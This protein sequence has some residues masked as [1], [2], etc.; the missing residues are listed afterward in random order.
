MKKFLAIL[1]TI[2]AT[3]TTIVLVGLFVIPYVGN[4]AIKLIA[5]QTID[6]SIVDS[7]D[8]YQ[9]AEDL[10]IEQEKIDKALSNEEM[11]EYVNVIWQEILTK[12]AS[13]N[14]SIDEDLIKEKTKEFLEKAN[15][16]YDISLDNDK[17]EELTDNASKA[18]IEVSNELLEDKDNQVTG[19]LDVITFCSN[20]KVR[21][22]TIV[23]LIIELVSIALLTLQKL[24]FFAYY[25]FI[26][27]F[28][29]ALIG[30]ATGVISFALST[31]KELMVLNS[32]INKGYILAGGLVGL[33][34]IFIIINL[35]IKH[36]LNREV[37]PF[38]ETTSFFICSKTLA[39]S[40]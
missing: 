28:T 35:I 9:A 33:G 4:E 30:L 1:L 7:N 13:N 18:V 12:K 23:L 37:V 40:S 21:V 15:K 3:A 36:N 29:A 10:G 27:F 24:S 8:L 26:S 14:T 2:T 25:T 39:K 16:N 17:I 34:I 22:L 5:N 31:D 32:I 19:F 6:D 38:Q 20:S 11:K